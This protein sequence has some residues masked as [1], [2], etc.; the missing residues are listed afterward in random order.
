MNRILTSINSVN[1]SNPIILNFRM[2]DI[3]Q[4]KE[5]LCILQYIRTLQSKDSM[6]IEVANLHSYKY[7]TNNELLQM[8]I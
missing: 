3:V 1:N 6:G 4:T 7:M 8:F 2:T 5:K